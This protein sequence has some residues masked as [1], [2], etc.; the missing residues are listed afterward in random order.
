MATD[1]SCFDG[2]SFRSCD[3]Q[4]P[5]FY[6]GIGLKMV[7]GEAVRTMYKW[8]NP[9]KCLGKSGSDTK[10]VSCTDASAKYWGLKDGKLSQNGGQLCVVRD[11]QNGAHMAKCPTAF[12]YMTMT[13]PQVDSGGSSQALETT[14]RSGRY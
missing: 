5:N 2:L 13:I 3:A 12:E 4:N 7:G 11:L 8:H 6:F 9:S 1:G 14:R 10:L